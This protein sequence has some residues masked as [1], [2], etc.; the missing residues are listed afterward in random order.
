MQGGRRALS[1][2]LAIDRMPPELLHRIIAGDEEAE[3]D[4]SDLPSDHHIF[5]NRGELHLLHLTLTGD[6]DL[7]SPPL[8]LVLKGCTHLPPPHD[9]RGT[10]TPDQ[11]A[12]V[13]AAAARVNPA[14]LRVRFDRHYPLNHTELYTEEKR[15]ENFERI[16]ACFAQLQAFYAEAAKQGQLVLKQFG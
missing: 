15:E 4:A 6:F 16:R 12:E 13:A 14:G 1:L 5:L 10:L 7:G 11:I 2:E 8:S 3:M 9:M